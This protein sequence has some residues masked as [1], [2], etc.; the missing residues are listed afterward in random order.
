[1]TIKTRHIERNM[2][3]KSLDNWIQI[4]FFI[5]FIASSFLAMHKKWIL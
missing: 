3:K 4:E 1:M 5:I 2:K